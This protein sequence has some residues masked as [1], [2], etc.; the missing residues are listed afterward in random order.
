MVSRDPLERLRANRPDKESAMYRFEVQGVSVRTGKLHSGGL[1]RTEDA[2]ND[3]AAS[4]N[5]PRKYRGP[6]IIWTVVPFAG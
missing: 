5:L 6:A 3:V 1:F 2:A 4:G